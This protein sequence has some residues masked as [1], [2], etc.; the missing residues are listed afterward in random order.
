MQKREMK[1]R[2]LNFKAEI[3]KALQNPAIYR[4][5]FFRFYG[6]VN[7]ESTRNTE[8]SQFQ[9]TVIENIMQS[10]NEIAAAMDQVLEALS[11]LRNIVVVFTPE[12]DRQISRS[13]FHEPQ[14]L[15][16]RMERG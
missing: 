5:I 10:L 4:R 9:P 12:G 16:K 8:K 15:I 3:A 7:F 14:L 6:S 13:P 2:P 1:S 11:D